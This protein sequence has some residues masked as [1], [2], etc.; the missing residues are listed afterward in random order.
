MMAE[1]VDQEAMESR[2]AGVSQET[3]VCQA[4]VDTLARAVSLETRDSQVMTVLTET[5]VAQDLSDLRDPAETLVLLVMPDA[6]VP[7]V[8]TETLDSR[9][10]L[11]KMVHEET[12]VDLVCLAKRVLTVTPVAQVTPDVQERMVSMDSQ[13][14]M[15]TRVM[16][17]SQDSLV[18]L[19]QAAAVD[20]PVFQE[21]LVGQVAQDLL[22]GQD[23]LAQLVPVVKTDATELKVAVVIRVSLAVMVLMAV[24]EAKVMLVFQDSMETTEP[25]DTEVHQ[26]TMAPQLQMVDLDLQ[27]DQES[28]AS[29]ELLVMLAALALMDVM[30]FQERTAEMA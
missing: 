18:R 2:V 14:A 1:M 22:D 27:D 30:E 20:P 4:C 3:M 23:L 6:Q 12:T 28:L 13:A 19:E 7:Q 17:D 5:M 11:V 29:P 21:T 10:R 24:M 16:R 25:R 15:A 26:E 9:V 8:A